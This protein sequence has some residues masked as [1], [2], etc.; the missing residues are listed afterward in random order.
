MNHNEVTSNS[1][2]VHGMHG[3]GLTFITLIT[4]NIQFNS[5]LNDF[6]FMNHREWHLVYRVY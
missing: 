4:V 5:V 6:V 3:V 1:I 2:C